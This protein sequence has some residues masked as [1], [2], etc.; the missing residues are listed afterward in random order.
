MCSLGLGRNVRHEGTIVIEP[1]PRPL[2][3]QEVVQPEQRQLEGIAAR[4]A[5][6]ADAF[7]RVAGEPL[8]Q[9]VVSRPDL[10]EEQ[11][12]HDSGRGDQLF[13]RPLLVLGQ[14]GHVRADVDRR[15]TRDHRAELRRGG[16]G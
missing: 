13:H 16:D 3:D 9:R 8:Q 5:T 12:V 11:C 1:G 2:V 10:P 15:E 6:L 4:R 14:C 7:M